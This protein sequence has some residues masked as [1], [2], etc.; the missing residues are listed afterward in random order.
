[1]AVKAQARAVN[2]QGSSARGGGSLKAQSGQRL[3]RLRLGQAESTIEAQLGLSEA[4]TEVRARA[5]GTGLLA[6]Q[7]NWRWQSAAAGLGD[8]GNGG[9]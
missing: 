1:M 4:K 3:W 7:Q 9:G 5:S 8:S 2:K 6:G